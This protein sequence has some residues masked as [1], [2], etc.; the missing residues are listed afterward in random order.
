MLRYAV[1]AAG[2]LAARPLAA[3]ALAGAAMGDT[4][5]V[6]SSGVEQPQRGVLTA[7]RNDS[8]FVRRYGTTFGFATS[9]IER[10]DVLRKRSVL[11]GNVRGVG[12]GAPNGLVTR[13]VFGRAME[14]GPDD[15]GDDCG[16]ISAM[17]SVTGLAAGAGLGFIF[18][19]A[20]PGKR[21]DQV[22]AA[23]P[24]VAAVPAR[25]GGVALGVT[26]KL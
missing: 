1:L 16:L 3:Q 23:H 13:N 15:C 2:L 9:Q 10:I 11:A 5:R 22:S 8:V 21:W 19:A 12:Y 25:D 26:M 6:F 24:S 20:M 18:G 4:V 7:V 17:L 14:G